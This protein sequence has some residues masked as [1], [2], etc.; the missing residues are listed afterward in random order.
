MGDSKA[1]QAEFEWLKE[2]AYHQRAA[3][4]QFE[5]LDALVRYSAR[6]GELLYHQL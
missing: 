6:P 3:V 1:L 2:H 4:V 5:K